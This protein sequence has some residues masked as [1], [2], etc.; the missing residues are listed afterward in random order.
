MRATVEV[1]VE[2][3]VAIS[4]ASFLVGALSTGVLWF[5]HSR[6]LRAKSDQLR[7]VLATTEAGTELQSML[8]KPSRGGKPSPPSLPSSGQGGITGDHNGN[9]PAC[10]LVINS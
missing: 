9:C 8:V 6:A 3:A 2:V 10:P 7:S 4:L 5:L 1:P